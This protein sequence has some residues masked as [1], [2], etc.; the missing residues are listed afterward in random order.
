MERQAH[1]PINW[2]LHRNLLSPE[3]GQELQN[4]VQMNGMSSPSMVHPTPP[5]PPPQPLWHQG[6]HHANWSRQ[7]IHRSEMVSPS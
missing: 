7:N 5:A 3:E 6:L 1:S 2:D 4:N